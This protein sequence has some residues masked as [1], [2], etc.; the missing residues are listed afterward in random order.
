MTALVTTVRRVLAA[1]SLVPLTLA[2]AGA[3]ALGVTLARGA[4]GGSEGFV[5]EVRAGCLP[6]AGALVLS[7]AE[8]LALAEEARSGLVLLR[9]SRGGGTAL[10]GR[11]AGLL[12][13]TLPSVLICAL[14]TGG[15]PADPLAL[16]L[17]LAV[18]AA[19]GLCLGAWLARPLLVPALW[20]LLVAGYLRPW[21]GDA[22]VAWLL[23]ALGGLAGPAGALHA[24]LWAAGALVLADVRLR[25]VAAGAG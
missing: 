2:A 17:E 19:G 6:F 22:P 1:P 20:C 11:C 16:L 8:P 18:L 21:F 4:L 24:L 9:L 12:L 5:D 13:A 23:P 10:L 3:S 25:A 7:L 14:A 15:L